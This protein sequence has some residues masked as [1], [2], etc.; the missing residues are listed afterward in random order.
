MS[1]DELETLVHE[2]QETG[3]E[4]ANEGEI[5]KVYKRNGI[6]LAKPPKCQNQF[7][8]AAVISIAIIVF[9]AMMIQ[10]WSDYGEYIKTHT[11]PPKVYSM[12]AQCLSGMETCMTKNYNAPTCEWVGN[13]ISCQIEKPNNHMIDTSIPYDSISWDTSLNITFPKVE[14]CLHL[15]IWSI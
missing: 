2:S 14:H 8:K 15:T 9:I 1:D 3:I 12:S 13:S 7:C 10:I 5:K 4:M 6:Q 11:F